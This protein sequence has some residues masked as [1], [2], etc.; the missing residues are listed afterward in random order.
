MPPAM[1]KELEKLGVELEQGS[2]S[3]LDRGAERQV[4]PWESAGLQRW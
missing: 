4:L 1:A 2:D 3:L